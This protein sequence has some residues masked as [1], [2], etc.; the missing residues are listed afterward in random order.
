MCFLI[1]KNEISEMTIQTMLLNV[2]FIDLHLYWK[3]EISLLRYVNKI[4]K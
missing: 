4:K 2:L 1:I 3:K